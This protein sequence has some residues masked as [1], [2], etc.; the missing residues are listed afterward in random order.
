MRLAGK[1]ALVTGASRGIGR[2]IALRFA[3]EGAFV[4]VN[5]A[6]NEAAAAE[7][8][9]AI[10]SAGG[11][12]VLSRFDVG[13]AVEVDTAV[14][15]IVA[16]RG[17][18]DILVNN[19]GV[20][21][22]NLLMRLTEDDFDAVVRTNMKGTFLVTKAVSRQMIRQRAGRIV[23]MS[24]VVGE[25]GNA[26]QSVYAATK[27]GILGFTRSMARELASREITVNAIAPGFITTDMTGTLPEAA[28]K[29]ML[30]IIQ[31]QCERLNRY[32]TNLLN[33]GRLQAGI[34]PDQ[35]ENLDLVEMLGSAVSAVK[36]HH[37]GREIIKSLP[38]DA[39]TVR[40]NPV[41]L[42]QL[43]Y[44]ILENAVQY[45]P[46]A[47]SVLITGHKQA[48]RVEIAISDQG[49]G[50]APSELGRIFDRFYRS[51][52]NI[53]KEGH[54]LGL[55]IA[56]GFAQAFGGEISAHS[57]LEMGKGTRMV[58][59]LPALASQSESMDK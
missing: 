36:M 9:E 16:A 56:S 26:G 13:S 49:C 58:V 14:K 34:S 40:A 17:R 57:P 27:A 51:A 12:A 22:D 48:G 24:S 42:E 50:I 43:F 21:R 28:R 55:S 29:E 30:T 54:G 15:A 18:I 35:L 52:K 10:G 19:A 23:N 7:T 11:Q 47:A 4:V 8:L 25:M 32:T 59:R 2:A 44:N 39:C 20:T 33:L 53:R 38:F 41:M 3:A 1:T 45:S 46:D 6:G 5:Y 37:G 31:D